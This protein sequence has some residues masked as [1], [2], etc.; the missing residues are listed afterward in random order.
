MAQYFMDT[1]CMSKVTED[2]LSFAEDHD[3]DVDEQPVPGYIQNVVLMLKEVAKYR[4]NLRALLR[5]DFQEAFT[6]CYKGEKLAA[7][8][9]DPGAATVELANLVTASYSLLATLLDVEDPRAE[10]Y[11]QAMQERAVAEAALAGAGAALLGGRPELQEVPV[12]ALKVAGMLVALGE[13]PGQEAAG[14]QVVAQGVVNQ[15]EAF[16]PVY[17]MAT[18]WLIPTKQLPSIKPFIDGDAKKACLRILRYCAPRAKYQGGASA[19]RGYEAP[20]DVIDAYFH[21]VSDKSDH[22]YYHTAVRAL[23]Y[24]AAP[25][26][27][28]LLAQNIKLFK[29]F[30]KPLSNWL[31]NMNQKLVESSLLMLTILLEDTDCQHEFVQQG[32][33]ANLINCLF[34]INQSM[35]SK[36]NTVSRDDTQKMVNYALRIVSMLSK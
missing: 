14:L 7:R 31:P 27:E 29:P 28:E 30:V 24:L 2:M 23:R 32:G 15:A 36:L 9:G 35:G 13:G 26:S 17:G 1:D 34:N 33:I 16:A 22:P 8:L 21:C 5:P 10:E 12:E 3:A 11:Q 25:A 20:G 18:A 4:I 19:S 6:V